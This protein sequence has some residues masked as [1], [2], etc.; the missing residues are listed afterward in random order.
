MKNDYNVIL[1]YASGWMYVCVS[2]E[3]FKIVG[4]VVTQFSEEL[5]FGS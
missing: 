5:N 4:L 3:I 1:Y 2:K